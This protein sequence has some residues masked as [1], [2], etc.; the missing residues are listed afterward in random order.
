MLIRI[1][2]YRVLIL[3]QSILF[4]R[5]VW[6]AIR[7][8]LFLS[9][10][11]S[12]PQFIDVEDKILGPLTLKQGIYLIG[13]VG[14]CVGLFLKFGFFIAVIIGGPI[15]G[16]AFALAFIKVHGRSFMYTLSSAVFFFSKDKLYLWRKTP[17]KKT[18]KKEKKSGQKNETRPVS[19]HMRQSNLKKLAWSLD[20]RNIF[21]EKK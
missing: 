10:R 19:V 11:F 18:M 2:K 6:C 9:M 7:E 16:L 4:T 12:V 8:M 14:V 3:L 20:T 1:A 5:T 17:K 13:G 15:L 21:D